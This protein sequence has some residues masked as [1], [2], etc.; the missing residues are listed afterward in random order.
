M[1]QTVF[2]CSS[3][4]DLREEREAVM[5]AIRRLR[6]KHE[7]MEFFGAH[8]GQPLETCMAQVAQS[9]FLVAIV[10][11]RYGSRVPELDI[12]YSEAEYREARR[13]D[14]PC[15][16]YIRSDD[17]PVP[18]RFM[19]MDPDG[20]RSLLAW[21]KVLRS[22]HTVSEFRGGADLA[23]T[24]E[25]DL[26]RQL[27]DLAAVARARVESGHTA[28]GDVMSEV[29]GLVSAALSR[30]APAAELLSA[31]RDAVA[32][33]QSSGVPVHGDTSPQDPERA[34]RAYLSCASEDRDFVL[35][36]ADA[37]RGSGLDVSFEESELQ[38]GADWLVSIETAITRADYFIF[39]ISPA[40]VERP[41]YARREL[42]VALERTTQMSASTRFLLPVL[43]E[44]AD[45]P[46]LLR[47]TQ[48]LDG[49][50]RDP[51]RVASEVVR[52]TR[53]EP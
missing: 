37:L 45:V 24:V 28:G 41:T 13:L 4:E 48:W 51:D 31:I 6:L 23:A 42:Q 1:T 3:Y 18:P 19:E 33:I 46:M 53:R 10:G 38:A 15:L 49:R 7:T 29:Q 43:L 34:P 20:L 35:R 27:A 30:G 44:E 47:Q 21:K 26:S 9:D 2:I 12:S 50:D 11:H 39:F 25:K 32:G 16:V 22:R 17:E 14:R 36:V 40:S 52:A 5:D 8:P